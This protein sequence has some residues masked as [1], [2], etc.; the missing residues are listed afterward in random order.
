MITSNDLKTILLPENDLDKISTYSET[1]FSRGRYNADTIKATWINTE[2]KLNPNFTGIV[3]EWAL[4]SD[5]EPDLEVDQ[6]LKE[7]PLVSD[8]GDGMAFPFCYPR[9]ITTDGV[10]FDIKTGGWTS[11]YDFSLKTTNFKAFAVNRLNIKG[12]PTTKNYSK[13]EAFVFG[14]FLPGKSKC[15]FTGWY[16]KEALFREAEL[17]EREFDTPNGKV[18]HEYFAFPHSQLNP[19]S[20]L[21]CRGFRRITVLTMKDRNYNI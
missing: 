14:V 15:V 11:T 4:S 6:F 18:T 5:N 16:D 12:Q 10:I 20:D 21:L 2:K 8:A 3:G 7:R 13:I 17:V 19:F 1:N 9:M